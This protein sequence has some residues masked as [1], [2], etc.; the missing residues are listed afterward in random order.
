MDA[1]HDP[2]SP[3]AKGAERWFF[4]PIADVASSAGGILVA[5]EAGAV[6]TMDASL[7]VT[8]VY[9]DGLSR[10]QAIA[11]RDEQLLVADADLGLFSFRSAELGEGSL[12]DEVFASAEAW[13]DLSPHALVSTPVGIFAAVAMEHGDEVVQLDD[14]LSI[15]A[16]WRSDEWARIEDVGYGPDGAIYVV[17]GG[18][19]VF[20]HDNPE[21]LDGVVASTRRFCH[22]NRSYHAVLPVEDGDGYLAHDDGIDVF[23]EISTVEDHV[24]PRHVMLGPTWPKWHPRHLAHGW[25]D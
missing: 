3:E 14:A 10:P 21:Q 15:V 2:W 5:L 19:C 6:V 23:A 24:S 22:P 4:G 16:R 17:D 9:A 18:P 25:A 12:G 7:Q 11:T 8:G 20:M 1:V 13:A